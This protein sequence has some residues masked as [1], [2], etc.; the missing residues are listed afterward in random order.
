MMRSKLLAG[1]SVLM[2]I[3]RQAFRDEELDVPRSVLKDA[4]ATITIAS[5]G[6]Q[7]S[8][9]MLRQVRV[10]PDVTLDKVDPK[11][12]D[13]VVF[14]GGSGAS[15]YFDYLP[16]RQVAV[17]AFEAGKVVAAICI[18]PATLANAGVLKGKKATCFTSVKDALMRGGAR[19]S[20]APV[21]RDGQ[22][23]TADGPQSARAFG[24]AILDALA[25]K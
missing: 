13:A 4:G 15:E 16:A 18:A 11:A 23:I 14:I 3:A 8:V 12:Y 6:T 1:K 10:K 2:I 7:E 24:E 20:T 17:K 22:V 9:G 25:G 19:L 21:E 5:R